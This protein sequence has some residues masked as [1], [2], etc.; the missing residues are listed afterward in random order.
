M[1]SP[2]IVAS[3]TIAKS[4]IINMRNGGY[5]WAGDENVIKKHFP[6]SGIKDIGYINQ[7]GCFC[8]FIF[9]DG[10]KKHE[11]LLQSLLHEQNI[12]SEPTEGIISLRNTDTT[13]LSILLLRT[14]TTPI[15]LKLRWLSKHFD[16]NMC[17]ES[18]ASFIEEDQ[19]LPLFL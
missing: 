18:S 16:S 5:C 9:K 4:P 3:D 13:T 15:G 12:C 11:L 8:I 1:E 6:I 7:W 10:M 17:L 14:S 19:F 2:C